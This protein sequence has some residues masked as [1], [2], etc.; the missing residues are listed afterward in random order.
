M[1]PMRRPR[2]T[3]RRA[4]KLTAVCL[5][6]GAAALLL[7]IAPAVYAGPPTTTADELTG[8]QDSAFSV[9]LDCSAGNTSGDEL[10]ATRCWMDWESTS[11]EELWGDQVTQGR[12]WASYSFVRGHDGLRTFS[13]Y[14]V[15]HNDVSGA[16][17]QEATK[18]ILVKIDTTSPD[19][20]VSPKP[21]GWVNTERW[22][23]FT[24]T[25]PNMPDASGVQHLDLSVDGVTNEWSY[26]EGTATASQTWDLAAP[27]DH[28]NDGMHTFEYWATD[29][30]DNQSW[31]SSSSASFSV[32]VDTWKPTTKA[33]SA[34]QVARYRTATLKY[35]VLDAAPNGGKASGSIK[36]TNRRGRVV[37]SLSFSGKPLNTALSAKFTCTLAKG[38]YRFFVRAKDS[39]GNA[40][41]SIGSNRLTV[42]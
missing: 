38:T 22:L 21:S 35:K 23:T 32:G 36:I 9:W 14:S 4:Q 13:F 5:C 31:H 26:G 34:T 20:A 30:T 12:C 25:D 11:M 7:A 17:E 16:Y 39:A 3:V 15:G 6:L 10:Y 42:K 28:S 18:S 8:W 33:P 40:Q 41:A 29:W 27:A 37:K 19:V 2:R 24:A 1:D